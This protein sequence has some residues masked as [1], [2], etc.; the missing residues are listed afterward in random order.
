MNAILDARTREFLRTLEVGSRETLRGL[1]HG[2]H[3][4]KRRGISTDFTHHRG[5]QMGDPLKTLDWKVFARTGKHFVK[6]YIETSALTLWTVLDNS[7]SM[8][9]AP[10]TTTGADPDA[11]TVVQSKFELGARIAAALCALATRQQDAAGLAISGKPSKL[12]PARSSNKHLSILLHHLAQAHQNQDHG[13][14][15]PV[16]REVAESISPGHL[17]AVITDCFYTPEATRTM[18]KELRG[19][20]A[21]VMLFRTVSPVE[22]SFDFTHWVDFHCLEQTGHHRVDSTLLRDAYL[23]EYQAFASEWEQFAKRQG[24]GLYLAPTQSSIIEILNESLRQ[25]A[26]QS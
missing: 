16:L 11:D 15:A 3:R 2:I 6:Q 12:L 25:R 10:I 24:I 1:R 23:K 9:D 8:R 7:A 22:A 21:D 20:G 26:M 4:S 18:L 17:V 14:L 19:R 13:D 5:Y